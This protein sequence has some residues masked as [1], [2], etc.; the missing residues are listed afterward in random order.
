MLR[1]VSTSLLFVCVVAALAWA[2]WPRPLPVEIA[3]ISKRDILVSVE[4]EGKARIREIYSISAPIN[5]Q[6]LRI[7][8]HAGDFVTEG[9]TLVS[10]R[11]AAPGLLDARLKR[12]AEAAAASSRAAVGL[13]IAEVKQAEAQLVFLRTELT[14]AERLVLQ[15]A[16]SESARD[17]ARLAVDTASANLDSANASLEVRQ[18]ELERAEAALIETAASAGPCCTEIKAP[19][20]GQILRIPAESEQVVTA[21]TPLME[22]GD[23]A[24]LEITTDILS[25]DAVEV[26][27]GAS[28]VISSWGG[29]NLLARVRTVAPSAMT[30]VSALGI[31]EQRVKVTLDLNPE[32]KLKGLGDGF[33][34]V[35]NISVWEGKNVLAVPM[36]ALFRQGDNWA[37]YRFLKGNA[38]LQ[39]VTLGRGNDFYSE[40]I[41]GLAPD[42]AV[43]LH[44]SDQIANGTPV[45]PIDQN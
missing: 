35:V 22:I 33:R 45:V 40:V 41:A 28:A 9:E 17:K 42:D 26:K 39:I 34:V 24:K 21:G 30:K 19:I 18:R 3:T 2:L 44:P 38:K 20:S 11:P 7:E 8:H 12:V 6:T 29:Q 13:A 31:E 1:R 4:E 16:I 37:V 43:I 27:P 23:P 25:R 36:S 5:G 32:E 10:I 14:R 15:G